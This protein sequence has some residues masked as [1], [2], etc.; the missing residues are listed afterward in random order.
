MGSDERSNVGISLHVFVTRLIWACVVPL[1][2]LA[3][4]LAV[5]RVRQVQADLDRRISNQARALAVDVEQDLQ[6]R[7][8]G[9]QMLARSPLIDRPDGLGALHEEAQGFLQAFGSH[10]VM[11][12]LKG[13]MLMNTRLPFGT[14]LPPMPRPKGRSAAKAALETGQR[15]VGDSFIGPVAQQLLVAV[16]Q[17]VQRGGRNVAVILS[18]FETSQ[19]Q[20]HLERLAVPDDWA[21]SLVDSGGVRIAHKG[22]TSGSVGKE[23]RVAVANTPWSVVLQIPAPVYRASQ[24]AAAVT[25]SVA[26][27]GATLIGVIGGLLASRR[28]ARAVAMLSGEAGGVQEHLGEPAAQI[29]EINQAKALLDEAA[30]QRGESDEALRRSAERHLH[31]LDNMLEGCQ[32]LD[33][34][35]RYLYINAAAARQNRQPVEA[36]LGWRIQEVFPGIEHSAAFVP[37]RDCMEQGREFRGEVEYVFPD[38]NE[39]AWF[40]L[41]VRPAPEGIAIYSVNIS[42]RRR[43]EQAIRA[44]NAELEQRVAD[45]TAELVQAREAAEAANQAKSAFV[46]NMSHEIRTPMNAIIGLNYLL[47]RDAREPTAK[48]RLHQVGE[49]ASHL[50]QILNDILDLSKIEADKL[51]LEQTDFS[52]RALLERCRSL[53][54]PRAQEQGL[55][56]ALNQDE[57]LPDLLRGDPTRL[58]QALLN[59]LS[60]AIKFTE[61]GGVSVQVTLA[62]GQ[63]TDEELLIR[64]TVRDTGIGMAP[65][66]LHL[67]FQAF[68]QGDTSTT[69]RFGGTGLGLAITQRLARLMGGEVGVSS[70]LGEG[71]EFWF[72]ARLRRGEKLPQP[73]SRA[74]DGERL[75]R[76]RCAGAQVLLVED[77]P[78]NQQVGLELLLAAG[79]KV[80]VAGNGAEA[81]ARLEPPQRFDLILMDMQMPRMDGLEASRRIRAMA[82][83]QKLPI[84]AMT[85]NAFGED[86]AACLAAGMNDHV[87]KPVDP[88]EL[89]AAL[90]RWLPA[91]AGDASLPVA[92]PA[93]PPPEAEAQTLVPALGLRYCGGRP[94]AYRRVLEQF[95]QRYAESAGAM[96]VLLSQH[97]LE[98]LARLVHSLRG[99]SATI[100]AQ[101]LPLQVQRFEA[102][103][104]ELAQPELITAARAL[105]PEL[106]ALLKAVRELLDAA[107]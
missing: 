8:N 92:V 31:L 63:A 105:G 48:V 23:V 87:S 40:E 72:S 97:D 91:T 67:L 10:V 79:L 42:E 61:R 106:Q 71:S 98:G 25:L 20:P 62:G 3:A 78:V 85:A 33:R 82:G 27:L 30:R 47:Q 55:T 11:A 46:A 99:A 102:G 69:R 41:Y 35:W 80:E 13:Q 17:P 51:V 22:E 7:L 9:L 93:P 107:L 103:L 58:S 36:M 60:N 34:D 76:E 37:L 68:V 81:L 14:A 77:N 16:A 88:A 95:V 90:L 4:Y 66:S 70:R 43:A 1:V 59:L 94:D 5:D 12:D 86:R 32:I 28:L 73:L 6:A 15:A 64:F 100:G 54:H 89:Y 84:L 96:E 21:I 19:F 45:R 53:L 83:L 26:V 101:R 38:G 65:E 56:L 52:L 18:T 44:I 50:L 104:K 2:L 75:L 49:A 39:L 29:R 24:L 74:E 57:A